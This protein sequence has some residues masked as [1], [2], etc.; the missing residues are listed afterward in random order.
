M[1]TFKEKPRSTTGARF[2]W[3]NV[4]GQKQPNDD[5][6]HQPSLDLLEPGDKENLI[7]RLWALFAS[8]M[9]FLRFQTRME[10]A[11]ECRAKALSPDSSPSLLLV[12]LG[13]IAARC[14]LHSILSMTKNHVRVQC[15]H[16]QLVASLTLWSRLINSSQLWAHHQRRIKQAK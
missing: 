4:H 10:R 6:T 13:C 2:S 8:S 16:T 9:C 14:I 11:T 5:G 7:C 3:K 1:K 15:S 12:N